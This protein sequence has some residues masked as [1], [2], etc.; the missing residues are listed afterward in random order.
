V[1]LVLF[2]QPLTCN[3]DYKGFPLKSYKDLKI[4]DILKQVCIS[5]SNI[6][7]IFWL[8]ETK[9]TII[10]SIK[11]IKLG[12]PVFQ[13]NKNIKNNIK[14]ALKHYSSL[15]LN[16]NCKSW[17]KKLNHVVFRGQDRYQDY[18][19][20]NI[21]QIRYQ[22]NYNPNY[23]AYKF[24]NSMSNRLQNKNIFRYYSSINK[25]IKDN[26]LSKEIVKIISEGK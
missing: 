7:K 25:P 15:Q 1:E 6:K 2:D 20:S 5:I 14:L 11:H 17:L 24:C 26:K 4:K 8:T 16:S 19:R 13:F 21:S 3:W 9:N 12:N 22:Q 10:K 18:N 23:L